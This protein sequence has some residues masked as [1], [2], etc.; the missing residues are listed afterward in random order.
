MYG[1]C[2]MEKVQW[3]DNSL[4]I[5]C[6]VRAIEYTIMLREMLYMLTAVVSIR[7]IE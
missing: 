6:I 4:S 1:P 2:C 5:W 3:T 7:N